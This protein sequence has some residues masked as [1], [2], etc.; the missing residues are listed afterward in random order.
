MP[1]TNKKTKRKDSGEAVTPAAAVGAVTVVEPPLKTTST[2]ASDS[3]KSQAPQQNT[4]TDST[5]RKRK[6]GKRGKG[7]QQEE[8]EEAQPASIPAETTTQSISAPKKPKTAATPA[9]TASEKTT[10]GGGAKRKRSRK[11]NRR[12][13]AAE[14]AQGSSSSSSDSDTEDDEPTP[15]IPARAKPTSASS[16]D[17]SDDSSSD[18]ETKVPSAAKKAIVIPPPKSQMKMPS[19]AELG[20]DPASASPALS[21]QTQRALA[22]AQRFAR[23][24]PSWKFEKQRQNWLLRHVLDVYL[25]SSGVVSTDE[26]AV[27]KEKGA[28]G[29]GNGKEEDDEDGDVRIP[30]A[31]VHVLAYYY[32]HMVGGAK[33]RIIETLREAANK[34]I[35]DEDQDAAIEAIP[36]TSE[37]AAPTFSIGDLALQKEAQEEKEKGADVANAAKLK[38]ARDELRRRKEVGRRLLE[39][40]G[41]L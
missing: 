24:R 37:T 22:Y 34:V 5:T 39:L 20:P 13:T 1:R 41:E 21:E 36:S 10:A 30:G 23:D 32:A 2:P 27:E 25:S 29:A 28:N 15:V 6:R 35:P 31:Y 16:S 8:E 4:T 3:S 12:T 26:A 18:E 17:S 38:A 33:A 14:D 9:P 40:M 11:R 7:Q 19:G